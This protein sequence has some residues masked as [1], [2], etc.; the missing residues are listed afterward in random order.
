MFYRM[1]MPNDD[2]KQEIIVIKLCENAGEL[3]QNQQG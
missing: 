2:L 3:I 1:G